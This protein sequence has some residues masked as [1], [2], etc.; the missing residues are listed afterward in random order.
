[1][2]LGCVGQEDGS[3]GMTGY[4]DLPQTQEQYHT[5]LVGTK[6]STLLDRIIEMHP[7]QCVDN[8]TQRVVVSI[9]SQ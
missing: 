2:V 4:Q 9:L 1:M 6:P 5:F 3:E 7:E 8:S